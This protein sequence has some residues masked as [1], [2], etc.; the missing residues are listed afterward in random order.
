MQKKLKKEDKLKPL[1]AM[2]KIKLIQTRLR[3]IFQW[4]TKKRKKELIQ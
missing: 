4:S 2:E 1:E 3:V